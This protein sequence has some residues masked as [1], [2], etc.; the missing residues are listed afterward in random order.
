VAGIL[1]NETRLPLSLIR[2]GGWGDENNNRR[3]GFSWHSYAYDAVLDVEVLGKGEVPVPRTCDQTIDYRIK[4]DLRVSHKNSPEQGRFE[5][6]G[7]GGWGGLILGF[8]L[9][10]LEVRRR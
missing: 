10:L 7:E 6:T 2:N 1:L 3:P 4:I 8:C 9:K 5:K